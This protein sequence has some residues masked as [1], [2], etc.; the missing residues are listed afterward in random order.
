MRRLVVVVVGLALFAGCATLTREEIAMRGNLGDQ[1]KLL[2][3]LAD[4]RSWVRE[5]AARSLGNNR[6]VEAREL[7]E[8]RVSDRAEKVWVRSASAGALGKIGDARSLGLLA[9]IAVQPETPSEVKIAVVQ[10]MCAFPGEEPLSSIA[11]LA[12]NE[13]LLVASIASASLASSCGRVSQ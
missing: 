4:E 1:P 12:G 2:K 9:G 5:E 6:V 11:P 13:D 10:A 8:A 3:W 7:L